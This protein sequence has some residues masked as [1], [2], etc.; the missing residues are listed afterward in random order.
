MKIFKD[1]LKMDLQ[2]S[3]SKRPE[4]ADKK[5][6]PNF[7]PYHRILGHSIENCYVFKDWIERQY[8]EGNITLR[9]SVLL[10]QLAE[11]TNYVSV[12]LQRET[13]WR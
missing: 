9:K 12:A 6:H 3:E 5:D 8:Q 7:C 11:H 4:E 1:V 10:D 2:L 13:V